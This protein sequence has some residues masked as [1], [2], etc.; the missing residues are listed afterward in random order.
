VTLFGD[1]YPTPDGTAIR[2][3]IHV[4]DLADAHLAALERTGSMEPGQEV[5]NLGAGRGF[6]VQEVLAAAE[7]VVVRSIEHRVGPRR[8]GDPPVLVAAVDRAAK[9]LGWRPERS[10][11][12]EMIASAW[13]RLV[14]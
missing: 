13:A 4:V 5:F 8:A 3:Y 14:D 12:E 9:V 2:D 6:S 1:D 11:L 7:R 10:T